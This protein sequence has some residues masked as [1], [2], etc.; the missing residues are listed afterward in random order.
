[1]GHVEGVPDSRGVNRVL[2]GSLRK[3]YYLGDL[4]VCGRVILKLIFKKLYRGIERI[5]LA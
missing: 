4:G 5:D 3:R 2:Q 1:M